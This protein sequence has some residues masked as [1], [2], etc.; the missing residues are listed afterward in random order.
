MRTRSKKQTIA[1][2]RSSTRSASPRRRTARPSRSP[3]R[4]WCTTRRRPTRSRSSS[5]ALPPAGS[6]PH[7]RL[8]AF[9]GFSVLVRVGGEQPAVDAIRAGRVVEHEVPYPVAVAVRSCVLEGLILEIV[10]H[11]FHG[12]LGLEDLGRARRL[13]GASRVHGYGGPARL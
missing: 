4:T 8:P 11:H 2:A 5:N 7:G 3:T 6:L 10:S 1:R 13:D 12:S 9:D